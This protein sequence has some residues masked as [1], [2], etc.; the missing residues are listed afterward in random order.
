MA[1]EESG[2]EYPASDDF[3]TISDEK[4]Y[5]GMYEDIAYMI[6]PVDFTSEMDKDIAET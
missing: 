2:M 3:F 4:Y 6:M 1:E 5:Y